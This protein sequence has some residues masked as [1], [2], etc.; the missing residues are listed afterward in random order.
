MNHELTTPADTN[1]E[2]IGGEPRVLVFDVNE[3]LIDFESMNPLFE[4]IFGDARVMRE[5]LGQLIT[6]SMTITLSGLWEGYFTLGQGLLKMVGDIHG[7]QI[8]DDDVEEIRQAM[9]TM[10]A[11]PDVEPGLTRLRDAGFRMVTLTNSPANPDGQSPLEHA[12]LAPFFE[13]Q[14][15]VE[16][17]RAYKPATQVYHLVAQSLAVPPS[18]CFMVA[19]HVWDTVGAQSAGYTAGLI[20]RPGNAP[21]PV[22][23]LP[24]PNL[25]APDLPSLADQLIQ[26]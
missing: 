1:G 2:W 6:Y 25:V 22:A 10:P 17:V 12:G 23:S 4:K 18:T 16:T 7:V 8:T 20:T 15:T 24:Q 11:H 5:W 19:C 21:L 13:R 9:L 3:T 26:R 14:F